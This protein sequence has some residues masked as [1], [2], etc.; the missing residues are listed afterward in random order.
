MPHLQ[1]LLGGGKSSDAEYASLKAQ[2]DGGGGGG[3]AEPEISNIEALVGAQ[4][5]DSDTGQV[6]QVVKTGIPANPFRLV[7][8]N[9]AS[10]G[11]AVIASRPWITGTG[12]IV[13]FGS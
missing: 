3:G 4:L 9:G 1:Y 12:Q 5:L 6:Y 7:G 2:H 8:P 10:V 11:M 13:Q